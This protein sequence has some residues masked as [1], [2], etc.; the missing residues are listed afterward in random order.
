MSTAPTIEPGQLVILEHGEEEGDARTSVVVEAVQEGAVLVAQLDAQ[1]L[2]TIP[3]GA[4][5]RLIVLD[6][7]EMFSIACTVGRAGESSMRLE[8]AAE[9]ERIVRRQYVRVAVDV[10]VS[11]LILNNESNEWAPFRAKVTDISA[12]GMAMAADVIAP[13]G[14]TIVIS[15]AVPDETPV[16]AIGRVLPAD[17]ETRKVVNLATRGPLVRVEYSIIREADRDRLMRFIFAEMLK[18]RRAVVERADADPLR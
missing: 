10:P 5:I 3:E 6:R 14:A 17:A 4:A 2:P 11:C 15:I 12:G 8:L 7:N 9:A 1:P 18:Q 16:V 13:T